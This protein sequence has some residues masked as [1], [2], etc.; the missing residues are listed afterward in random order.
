MSDWNGTI[1]GPPHVRSSVP[2]NIAYANH[3]PERP[4]EPYLQR[5][6]SLR[7]RLPRHTSGDQIHLQDQP[8]LREPSERKGATT[9]RVDT[10]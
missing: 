4:R 8:T 2:S 10:G 3:V 7:P 9:T 5:I 6:D 1:L